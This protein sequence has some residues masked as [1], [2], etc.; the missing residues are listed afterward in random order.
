MSLAQEPLSS[1]KN[2]TQLKEGDRIEVINMEIKQIRVRFVS[3]SNESIFFRTGKGETVM[4]R[5]DVYRVLTR[6]KPR[7]A[8]STLIGI[9]IGGGITGTLGGIAAAT[10]TGPVAGFVAAFV[11]AGVGIGALIGAALPVHT[12]IY[13]APERL[14]RPKK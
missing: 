10:A 1:W 9:C 2:L 6:E 14:K 3:F 4:K 5:E 13:R 7:R 8:H 12:E 11:G